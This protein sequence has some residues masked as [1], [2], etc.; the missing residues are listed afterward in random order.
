MFS[1]RY[2]FC[3]CNENRNEMHVRVR[4]CKHCG[5][6]FAINRRGR[7][8]LYCRPSHRVRAREKRR[9]AEG[10]QPSEKQFR[11]LIEYLTRLAR[12]RRRYSGLPWNY[13][14]WGF[15]LR[16][17]RARAKVRDALEKLVPEV[18][19]GQLSAP[20]EIEL[21]EFNKIF[22]QLAAEHHPDRGG[23][24]QTMQALNQVRQ[25]LKTDIERGHPRA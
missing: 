5:G 23:A 10:K 18:F 1:F 9:E 14:E 11:L 13:K 12:Q 17:E 20:A 3:Y 4:R 19:V 15:P 2:E 16:Y 24:N 6:R 7:P 25:A 21:R 8:Q 22:R